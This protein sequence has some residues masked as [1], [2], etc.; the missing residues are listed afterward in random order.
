MGFLAESNLLAGPE[1]KYLPY[2]LHVVWEHPIKCAS[3]S[4]LNLKKHSKGFLDRTDVYS[5]L[6]EAHVLVH[7]D[8]R[9][10]RRLWY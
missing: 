9:L 6:L 3:L 1:V 10:W 8:A 2:L 4:Y 5:K 7:V